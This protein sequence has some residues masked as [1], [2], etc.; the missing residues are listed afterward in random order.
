MIGFIAFLIRASYAS[1]KSLV[2][3]KPVLKPQWESFDFLTRYYGGIQ[4][5]VPSSENKPEYPTSDEEVLAN[6]TTE[7]TRSI[8]AIPSSKTFGAYPDYTSSAYLEKYAPVAECFLDAKSSIRI[9]QLQYYQGRP[10]GFPEHVMGSYGLLSLPQDICFE[11]YG[12]FG[13]YGHG[14]GHRLGGTG[15]GLFGDKEGAEAVWKNV[16]EVDYR[17]VDWADSQKRCFQA[18]SARFQNQATAKRSETPE[19]GSRGNDANSPKVPIVESTPV[20]TSEKKKLLPRT[21]V[22]IRTWDEYKYGADDILY[23]RALI[24]E[25][26]LGSGGEYDVHL[27]VQVK[28]QTAAIWADEQAYQTH[29]QLSVP[30]EFRGIATLWSES[31]S[32]MIYPGLEETWARGEGLPVH[33]VYRGLSMALQYFA[34][35]HAEYDFFWNWEMDIRYT[36]HFY[37]LFSQMAKWSAAQPRKG[38]WE[39]NG[40]FYIPSVHG[41]WDDFTHMVRVQTESG[42]ESAANIWSGIDPSKPK[43]SQQKG[44]KPIWGPERP[45]DPSDWFETD[46]DPIP[47]TPYAKDKYIWG[48]DEEAD[49]ITLNPIFDPAGTTWGLAKDVTG[50]NKTSSMPPRRASII[51]ASR[52]SRRLL[53]TMHRETAFGKHHAF[54]EMWPATAALHHGYKAVYVPHPMFIDRA[55]PL[56]YFAATMNAGR[57]GA[58]GGARTSVFG[59]REHNLL[60]SSWFYNAGFSGNLWKRWLGLRV[61]N[62]GGEEFEM[63][64]KGKIEDGAKGVP[65]MLGGEGRMCLPPMLLHPIKSVD[66]PVE[67]MQ[68]ASEEAE[69]GPDS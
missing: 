22:V 61:D 33:G 4:T 14:Y 7:S 60:G 49:L 2:D 40:R 3:R 65:A 11:R 17:S 38:L 6:T 68:V 39:R 30:S 44:D 16:Y 42:T 29:L 15:S 26:S 45:E 12:R 27:L 62:E 46:D 52:L 24:S 31:Q 20:Q 67:A 69:F 34:I 59:E 13:P 1:Q 37:T 35:K 57:N 25:L 51:A 41:T 64:G 36:G 66:L 10:S 43:A 5:L 23:L 48:V 53:T 32:A 55:W 47:P 18:N 8:R 54:S 58:S 50:Y 9:P 21:A 19:D 63:V 28:N 56:P